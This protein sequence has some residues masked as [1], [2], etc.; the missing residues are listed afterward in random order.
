MKQENNTQDKLKPC[1]F[2]GSKDVKIMGACM[3]VDNIEYLEDINVETGVPCDWTEERFDYYI[4]EL[5]GYAV[6]CDNCGCRTDSRTLRYNEERH[7]YLRLSVLKDAVNKRNTRVDD[8]PY[9]KL[10][11]LTEENKDTKQNLEF[12]YNSC[13]NLVD[14]IDND[15]SMSH[16]EKYLANLLVINMFRD[17]AT[18]IIKDKNT[19]G[20]SNDTG[21]KDDN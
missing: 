8:E 15:S 3:D 19:E 16:K 17:M 20:L 5:Y 21:R 10:F 14:N 1:P 9:K 13:S 18:H 2:C 12:L 4:N 6:V 7:K 11:D